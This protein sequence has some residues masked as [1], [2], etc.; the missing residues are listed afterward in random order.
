MIGMVGWA[1]SMLLGA[2]GTELGPVVDPKFAA[3]PP[4]LPAL[5]GVVFGGCCFFFSASL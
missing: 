3:E 1:V 4:P 5:L 2:T